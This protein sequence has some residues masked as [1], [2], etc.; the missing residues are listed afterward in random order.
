MLANIDPELGLFSLIA[1]LN[2]WE[3]HT[4]FRPETGWNPECS[5]A[6]FMPD[7]YKEA[8]FKT[9]IMDGESLLLSFPEV[10]EASGL[11]Y[12]IKGH[13]NKNLLFRVEE[14][15][16]D[17]KDFLKIL[18]NPLQHTNGLNMI[19]R[20]DFMANLML[21]YLMGATEGQREKPVSLPEIE[22]K[23]SEW[24]GLVEESGSYILPFAEDAEYVGTSAYFYVKQFGKARFF[25][26][27]PESVSRFKNLLDL[28]SQ[29]GY[30]LS[31]PSEVV[32]EG[33]VVDTNQVDKMDNGLAWHGGTAKAWANTKYARILDPV[34]DSV[35]AGVRDVMHYLGEDIHT[36]DKN[37]EV[38]LK[39][40]TNSY[41]SDS[42]WPPNPTTPGRFNVQEAIDSLFEA[43]NA[44]KWTMA[45]NGLAERKSLYSPELM[46]AQIETI[47][48]EL[49]AMDYF[50][51][52]MS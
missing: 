9:L 40:V 35:Y 52:Q 19:C 44:L 13:S 10:R 51:E 34:C 26:P 23:L 16:K 31:L 1:G 2:A 28:S 30:E 48:D 3:E 49:M 17:K 27:E 36:G 42:R 25:E 5:W 14:Y 7:I 4:G 29:A 43:N 11:H 45:E 21:W 47:Q 33:R 22:S 41:V 20:S 46:A 8:G 12:D 18:T 38:A 50:E 37:L 32:E 6:H 39:S 15:I 24:K